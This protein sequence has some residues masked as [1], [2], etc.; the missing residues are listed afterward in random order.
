LWSFGYCQIYRSHKIRW[1]RSKLNP[2]KP[3]GGKWYRYDDSV[4][5]LISLNP[6]RIRMGHNAFKKGNVHLWNQ[7]TESGRKW[8]YRLIIIIQWILH[9]RKTATLRLDNENFPGGYSFAL[10][11]K[12]NGMGRISPLRTVLRQ[13]LWRFFTDG[14]GIQGLSNTKSCDFVTKEIIE[15]GCFSRVG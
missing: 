14:V 12:I 9:V 6:I 7:I 3:A 10:S 1:A 13:S 5:Y 8:F 2:K 15:I 4:H 11:F